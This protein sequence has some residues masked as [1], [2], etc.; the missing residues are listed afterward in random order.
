METAADDLLNANVALPEIEH[1]IGVVFTDSRG[2]VHQMRLI[3]PPT[4]PAFA[5]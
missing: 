5:G 2:K 3:Y 4:A 1:S